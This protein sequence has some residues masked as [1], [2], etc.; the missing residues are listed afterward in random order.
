[1]VCHSGLM[2]N[3]FSLHL[4]NPILMVQAAETDKMYKDLMDTIVWSHDSKELW[5]IDVM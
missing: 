4:C 2:L 3:A 5:F 1:M